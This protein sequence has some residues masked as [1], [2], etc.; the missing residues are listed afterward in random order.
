M[1]RR[2]LFAAT[3]VVVLGLAS[4][5]KS[6]FAQVAW[7]QVLSFIAVQGKPVVASPPLLSEHEIQEL[8]HMAPQ[9]Q[10][11]LLL[12]RA[13]NHYQ[14]ATEWIDKRVDSWRG[15]LKI[16]GQLNTLFTSAI[17]SND[18]RVRA[19]ALEIDLAAYNVEK[20]PESVDS[21]IRALE[22][23]EGDRITALWLLGLLGNRGVEP[24]RV[25]QTLLKYTR[26]QDARVRHWAV[27]GLGYLGTDAI[28]EPLLEIFRTDPSADVR[29]RAACNLAQSGMLQQSQRMKAAPAFLNY[30]ED[31]SLD[32][33]MHQWVIQALQDISGLRTGDDPAAWRHWYNTR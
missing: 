17:N 20:V 26:D 30:L 11:E 8:D 31:S 24:D 32:P 3:A 1:G 7:Q 13:I 5:Y 33:T 12:E 4:S 10:A 2:S 28:I 27:E 6:G 23:G 22:A 18:L 9:Q 25:L 15:S 19:A 21:R 16:E 29:E 14:G